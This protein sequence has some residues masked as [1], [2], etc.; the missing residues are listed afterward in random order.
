MRLRALQDGPDAF[1][2]TFER[3]EGARGVDQVTVV[4][5][6]AGRWIGIATARLDV[7]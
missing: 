3:E 1:G 2:S 4:A 5:D 7:S 6:R